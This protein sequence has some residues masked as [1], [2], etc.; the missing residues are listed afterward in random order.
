MPT[1]EDEAQ[2]NWLQLRLDGA[3]E[4]GVDARALANLLTDVV[5][6]AR[7][8]ADERLGVGP[9]RG[10]MNAV[11]RGLASFRVT[12]VSPG[13]VVIQL[14]APPTAT[15]RQLAFVSQDLGPDTIAD[16]LVSELKDISQGTSHS[17][18]GYERRR[19]V[20]RIVRSAGQIG[21][22]AEVTR[23][24]NAVAD[25]EPQVVLL[26]LDAPSQ[27]SA[28]PEPTIR[29][30]VLYGHVYMADVERGRQRLRIKLPDDSDQTMA[31]EDDVV[32]HTAEALGQL[33][34]VHVSEAIVDGRIVGRVVGRIRLLDA[35]ER[36]VDVP[37]KSIQQLAQEQGLAMRSAPDYVELL[38][39]LWPTESDAEEFREY[40][41][42]SRATAG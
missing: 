15:E 42:T 19:M 21:R 26:R 5:A 9:R 3:I 30:T 29:Q 2:R 31:I 17:E 10:P 20:E 23:F 8:I 27:Q 18:G 38:N 6:A 28:V 24:N 35:S 33:A 25:A 12:S 16:S 14:A 7:F 1:A 34:E 41:R 39:E 36:G 22:V 37:P 40:L 32:D 4:G 13:S 11:E